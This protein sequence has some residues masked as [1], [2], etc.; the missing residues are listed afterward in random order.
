MVLF[1]Q[2]FSF[3]NSLHFHRDFRIILSIP[4]KKDCWYFD[5]DLEVNMERTD[6]LTILNLL[7]YEQCIL[8]QLFRPLFSHST[9]M[10]FYVYWSY[11]Y[12]YLNILMVLSMTL[13]FKCNFWLFV[14]CIYKYNWFLYMTYYS[15]TLLNSLINSNTFFVNFI[16]LLHRWLYCLQ[17]RIVLYHPF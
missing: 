7:A 5:W 13:F 12:S 11:T 9:D 17:K 8:F 4:T 1:C 14:A 6:M 15:A 2:Y 3:S 16:L 10:Q